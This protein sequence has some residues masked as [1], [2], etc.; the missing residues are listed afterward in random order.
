M[1]AGERIKTLRKI[2]NLTQDEVG[3]K[4]G[5]TRSALS[6][7]EKGNRNLTEQMLISI[8]RE[9]NVNEE[10]LRTGI[11]E[12]FNEAPDSLI[13]Q[14]A[15]EYDLDDFQKKIL[16][17]YLSLSKSQKNAVKEFMKKIIA[18]QEQ[19]DDIPPEY[20]GMSV[21]ELE[22]KRDLLDKVI[23]KKQVSSQSDEPTDNGTNTA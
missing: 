19:K 11:G 18:E 2:L 3:K 15:L 6:N 12:M 1:S 23:E 13:E 8:C 10:W 21:S 22:E 17:E 9:F 20:Q 14:V 4:I 16:T 7:I 5:V